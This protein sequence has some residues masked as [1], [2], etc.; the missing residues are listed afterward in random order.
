MPYEHHTDSNPNVYRNRGRAASFRELGVDVITQRQWHAMSHHKVLVLSVMD[1]RLARD[2]KSALVHLQKS[3]IAQH[4]SVGDQVFVVHQDSIVVAGKTDEAK[5]RSK[6][7]SSEPSP[8]IWEV[9]I[10]DPVNLW[11]VVQRTDTKHGH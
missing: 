3:T 8:F 7:L 10:I 11:A 6:V 2:R 4:I 1:H 5:P 9:T